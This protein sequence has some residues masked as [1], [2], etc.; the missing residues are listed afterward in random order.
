MNA[1]LGEED[2]NL[3]GSVVGARPPMRLA[4]AQAPRATTIMLAGSGSLS[5]GV[6]ASDHL[7]F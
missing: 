5:N 4:V 3:E 7:Q 2:P 1:R 6:M